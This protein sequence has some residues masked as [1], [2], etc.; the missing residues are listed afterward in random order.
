MWRILQQKRP[1]DYV[2]ATGEAHTV[3]EFA[4]EAFDLVGLDWRRHV[5]TDPRYFRPTE[6]ALLRGDASKARRAL[7]W[8][9]KTRFKALVRLMVEAELK[10]LGLSL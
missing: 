8:R 1:G 3:K 10:E 9:P 7:G 5:E 6:V 2:V 4:R